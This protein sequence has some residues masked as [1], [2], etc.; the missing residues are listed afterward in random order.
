MDWIMRAKTLELGEYDGETPPKDPKG[1]AR[2]KSQ[3]NLSEGIETS[4]ASGSKDIPVTKPTSPFVPDVTTETATP[5]PVLADTSLKPDVTEGVKE[6]PTP[7]LKPDGNNTNTDTPKDEVGEVQE[8]QG[9]HEEGVENENEQE[10]GNE[11]C[12]DGLSDRPM[13]TR[14]DQRSFK[15]LAG[16]G[17]PG[18][19]KG[20]AKAATKKPAANKVLKKPSAKAKAKAKAKATSKGRS[21]AAPP[22]QEQEEDEQE[23]GEEEEKEEEEVVIPAT[24]HYSPPSSP[25]HPKNLDKDFQAVGSKSKRKV[26]TDDAKDKNKEEP[27]AKRGKGAETKTTKAEETSDDEADEGQMKKTFAGRAPPKRES[28]KQR[29]EIMQSTYFGKIRPHVTSKSSQVEVGFY[30]DL[31]KRFGFGFRMF[32]FANL[33]TNNLIS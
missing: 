24:Q 30:F 5:E 29:F 12:E 28:A 27:K 32:F 2:A 25:V 14:E 15:G 19:K 17:R 3:V 7:V 8:T 10:T 4:G 22:E 33:S 9:E 23:E 11:L 13:V 31:E 6:K 20:D 21:K 18:R 1:L 16:L 26:S